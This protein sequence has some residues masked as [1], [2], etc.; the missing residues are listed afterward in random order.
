MRCTETSKATRC[1]IQ[2]GLWL[3]SRRALFISAKKLLVVA[4]LHWGYSA[5]HRARGNLVPVWGDDFIESSLQSLI[6][7]YAP[8]ETIWLGDSLH[9]VAGRAPAEAFLHRMNEQGVHITV[10]EGNHDRKWR[11]PSARMV[12]RDEYLF[13]HGDQNVTD[14]PSGTMEVVGHHHPAAE[15]R[16]GAGTRLR[17][18]A[19]VSSACRMILPALS[20]WAGG[21]A[22]NLRLEPG[23]I[24]WAIAPSRIFAVRSAQSRDQKPQL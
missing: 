5:A 3:D 11:V 6:A 7:E 8:K 9:A 4:D 21:V 15:L 12:M 13:H 1:E 17:L 23:E 22:W 20:P 16:D 10:V 18:P 14:L 19:L 24:L 2:P